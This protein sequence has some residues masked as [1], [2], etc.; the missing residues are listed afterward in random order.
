MIGIRHVG[1]R[2]RSHLAWGLLPIAVLRDPKIQESIQELN[3]SLEKLP[4][5]IGVRGE[6]IGSNNWVIS[7][8]KTNTGKPILA[9]DPHLGVQMPSI[10][11]EEGGELNQTD[12]DL[13]GFLEAAL[14]EA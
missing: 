3:A 5:V 1:S 4:D 11:Y 9:N 10:W 7:G 8:S 13:A 6:S 14:K 12:L 2:L